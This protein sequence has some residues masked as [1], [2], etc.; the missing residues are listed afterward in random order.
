MAVAIAEDGR[1]GE[2]RFQATDEA[3]RDLCRTRQDAVG[4]RSRNR[5]RLQAFL[6]RNG[7]RYLGKSAWTAAHQRYLRELVMAQPAHV[8]STV[9]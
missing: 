8:R 6:L 1:G 2:V 5:Q 3:L 7:Y 9:E 4:D